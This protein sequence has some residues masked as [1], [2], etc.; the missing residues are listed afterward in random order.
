MRPKLHVEKIETYTGHRD[1][2]YTVISGLTSGS[3]F[4]AGGDGQV[5][6]WNTQSP[7]LGTRVANMSHSV[8]AL[9]LDPYA[10]RLWIGHNFEGVVV[11]DLEDQTIWK[12]F[13]M[14]SVAIYALEGN[15]E[16]VWAGDG[17][18]RVLQWDRQTGDLIQVVQAGK[19]RIRSLS[20][21]PIFERLYV[22]SSDQQVRVFDTKAQR[23]ITE[24]K[25]HEGSVFG[26]VGFDSGNKLISVSRDAHINIWSVQ[27]EC[28]LEQSIPAHMYAIHAAAV[29]DDGRW[30]A[31]GS[32]DK[33]IKIWDLPTRQLVKVID[34]GRFAGHGTS[35]NALT[36]LIGKWELIAASDDRTLS[37]WSIQIHETN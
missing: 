13:P 29:S 4:S 33:S 19:E 20:F 25:A 3:F 10:K 24:W 2:V 28:A 18:G 5:V 23:Q 35:I 9:W 16:S 30:L 21:D 36:W 6:H 27:P 7:D 1:A 37:H 11:I 15:K 22:G 32:M 12:S 8:Y 17:H 31:T 34:K 26:L 14:G